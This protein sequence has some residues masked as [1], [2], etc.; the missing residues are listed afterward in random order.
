MK[1]IILITTLF[2][3]NFTTVICSNNCYAISPSPLGRLGGAY[4]LF[5][6]GFGE[7]IY[8]SQQ[9]A[10]NAKIAQ[11]Q[12]EQG[13]LEREE[14]DNIRVYPNPTNGNIYFAFKNKVET[15]LQISLYNINGQLVKTKSINEEVL[16][17]NI[18][19]DDLI[20]GIY[21]YRIT[22]ELKLLSSGKIVLIK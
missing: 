2:S 16:V 5:K 14:L 12:T 11:Q 20:D 8:M 4:I 6:K 7:K 9:Q 17:T 18:D 3:L 21:F 19:I 1:T 22:S 15:Q 13:K 10:S